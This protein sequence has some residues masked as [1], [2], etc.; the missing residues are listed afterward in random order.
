MRVNWDNGKQTKELVVYE[1]DD[2]YM[3]ADV[4]NGNKQAK[5]SVCVDIDSDELSDNEMN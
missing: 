3:F 1:N 5:K 4:I 2:I